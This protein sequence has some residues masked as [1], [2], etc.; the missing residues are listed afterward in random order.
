MERWEGGR[1]KAR[2]RKEKRRKKKEAR[3]TSKRE[4]SRQVVRERKSGTNDSRSLEGEGR[5]RR[6]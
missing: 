2:K 5:S 1:E 4:P 6:K 3:E